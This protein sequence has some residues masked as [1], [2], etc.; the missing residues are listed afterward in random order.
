V[1]GQ[2][3]HSA[4]NHNDHHD[5]GEGPWVMKLPL[6]LLAA[7]AVGVGFIPFS[8]FVTSDGKALATHIDIVFSIA[9]VVLSIV[10]ILLAANFYKNQNEKSDKV[11]VTFGGFYIAAY[12]KFYVDEV[13]IFITKKI[14]FPFIG[15]PIAWADKN[16]VDGFM[17]L[18]AKIT[19]KIA[20]LIKG[21]QSGKVQ[22]YAMY[23]FGGI[24]IL[25]ILFIYIWK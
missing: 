21:L 7:C 2:D 14:I 11:A 20:E 9:P 24:A 10:A 8:N 1:H 18:L 4:D 17:Q 23:F 25:S 5:H 3:T 12:K 19:A 15:Q 13:Y 16:I 6:I 22:N